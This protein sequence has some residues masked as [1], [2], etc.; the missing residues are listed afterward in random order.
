MG[1]NVRTAG[2]MSRKGKALNLKDSKTRMGR[3][4]GF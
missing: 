1:G 3:K 4:I 2:K